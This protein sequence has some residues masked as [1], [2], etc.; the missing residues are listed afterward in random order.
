MDKLNL[1]IRNPVCQET[2]QR[3]FIIVVMCIKIYVG[4]NVREEAICGLPKQKEKVFGGV[5]V[6]Y[7]LFVTSEI[8]SLPTRAKIVLLRI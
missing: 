6:C 5:H 2:L 3:N 8:L 1:T 4:D 7:L